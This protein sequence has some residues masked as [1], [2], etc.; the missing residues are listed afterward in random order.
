[1]R[2]IGGEYII[3]D[4]S[5]DKVDMSLVYTFSESA[6]WLWNELQDK[7][8]TEQTIVELLVDRYDVSIDDAATDAKALVE[9]MAKQGLLTP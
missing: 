3:V 8:F 4:P 7:E 1:M 5:K 9:V 2:E 6:A